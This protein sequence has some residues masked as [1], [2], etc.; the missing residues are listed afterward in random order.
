[1]VLALLVASGL[2]LP[3]AQAQSSVTPI[4]GATVPEAVVAWRTSFAYGGDVFAL[5]NP[6]FQLASAAPEYPI[7]RYDPATDTVS[8]MTSGVPNDVGMVGENQNSKAVVWHDGF[9][10]YLGTGARDDNRG[11]HRYDPGTD[12][13]QAMP[14][15]LPYYGHW[16]GVTAGTKILLVAGFNDVLGQPDPLYLYD[17]VANTLSASSAETDLA[18]TDGF[19]DGRYVYLLGGTVNTVGAFKRATDEIMRYDPIADTITTLPMEL[20]TPRH[21]HDVVWSGQRAYVIGGARPANCTV[22][23]MGCGGPIV[24]IDWFDPANG[25]VGTHYQESAFWGSVPAAWNGTKGYGFEPYAHNSRILCFPGN[26]NGTT[27]PPPIRPPVESV[28]GPSG[29][30]DPQRTPPQW[31]AQ[32]HLSPESTDGDADGIPDS[33]DNCPGTPNRGQADADANGIGD[34]CDEP[35]PEP[36]KAEPT[37][38]P[39][40]PPEPA[41]RQE[42][43]LPPQQVT[44]DWL[45]DGA[46]VTWSASE[47]CALDHFLVWQSGE[48]LPVGLVGSAGPGPQSY[49]WQGPEPQET[50]VRYLVQ[51]QAAGMAPTLD[52]DRAVPSQWLDRAC[53]ACGSAPVHH[54]DESSE[55]GAGWSWMAWSGLMAPTLLAILLVAW[56]RRRSARRSVGTTAG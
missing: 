15:E 11:I 44:A 4:M 5:G 52:S 17:P 56:R 9:A 41:C 54:G 1:M 40:P 7:Y 6:S 33:H 37:S 50:P 38:E 30:Y 34:A 28:A 22:D 27:T 36:K 43:P 25:T 29:S 53:I 51:A 48:D 47:D 55:T 18:R 39:D 26:C 42:T 21:G 32:N 23:L 2:A 19:Y 24:T 31:G 3:A 45:D 10:Y 16:I 20:P 46:G 49:F 35:V 8:K 13:I 14:V 12:T